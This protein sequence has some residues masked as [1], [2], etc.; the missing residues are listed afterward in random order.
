MRKITIALIILLIISVGVFIAL[1]LPKKK[2]KE[3]NIPPQPLYKE[4]DEPMPIKVYFATKEGYLKAEERK[5]FK[6]KEKINQIKQSILELIKGPNNQELTKTIP[7]QT[8]LREV[9]LAINEKNQII[10]YVDFSQE[11]SSNHPGGSTLELLTIY[12]IVSTIIDN[13]EEVYAVQI[14]IN[15][16]EK[17]TLAGHIDISKPLPIEREIIKL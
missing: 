8:K 15:G 7:D 13:F 2:E 10:V 6:S 1:T 14:L 11:I 9:Y 16:C 4:K 17:D 12:S 3:I 5:I